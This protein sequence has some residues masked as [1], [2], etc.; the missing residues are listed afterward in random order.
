MHRVVPVLL[1]SLA[2][3]LAATHA[4]AA[5]RP[6]VIVVVT[7][8][9][10]YGDLSCHGNPVLNTPNLDALHAESVRLTDFH[11]DPTC[12]PTRAALMSGRYSTRTGVWHTIAGRSLMHPDEVSL[13]ERFRDAGYATGIRGK[14]HLGDNAPCLPGQQGFDDVFVHGGGG[15]GQVP[16]HWGN[17]YFS[18]IYFRGGGRDPEPAEGYCTDVWFRDAE[19]FV[20]THRDEPFFLYVATNAPHSPYLVPDEEVAPFEAAGV[21]SPRAEFYGM[22]ARIDREFGRFRRT[23]GE[24]GLAENTVLVFLTDNGT[25]A[26]ARNGGFN[27]GM[28]GSKGS[29]YEGG[30]RVPCFVH[31]P[32]GNIGGPGR[33]FDLGGLT[34]HVDLFPTLYSLAGVE[35]GDPPRGPR[36]GIDLSRWLRGAKLAFPPRTLFVHSQ[37]IERPEKWRKCAVMTDRWRLVNGEELYDIEADPGQKRDLAAD[38]PGILAELREAYEGWW[39]SLEPV[40]DERVNILLPAGDTPVTLTAHDWHDP[41]N[42]PVPWNQPSILKE[43]MSTGWWAVEVPEDGHY[44]FT[45][46]TRPPETDAVPMGAR[47]VRVSYRNGSLAAGVTPDAGD[48]VVTLDL[49][50]GPTALRAELIGAD[51]EVRGAYYVV[52]RRVGPLLEPPVIGRD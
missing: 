6:N 4:R 23:L 13:A 44:E 30:H 21:E 26:G 32:A 7:D 33:G 3:G 51:G 16:D 1:A 11:V 40:F 27:A 52:V 43:P 38:R 17:D 24:L 29:E 8:D 28:R 10:G 42:R 5:D 36:D 9:Q 31:W 49:P 50:A 19:R 22:I 45:L 35:P 12:S 2:C 41:Q 39:R 47:S 15:V 14:W 46:R 18:D 37:R 48:A 20:R 25:A 34:A